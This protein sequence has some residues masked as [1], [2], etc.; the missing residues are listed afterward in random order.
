MNARRIMQIVEESHSITDDKWGF[1]G[2][3]Y[4]YRKTDDKE[5]ISP[6]W[7]HILNHPELVKQLKVTSEATKSHQYKKYIIGSIDEPCV[8]K[9]LDLTLVELQYL[10]SHYEYSKCRQHFIN[11]VTAFVDGKIAIRLC[12]MSE[13]NMSYSISPDDK[14]CVCPECKEYMMAMC[15]L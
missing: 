11:T 4:Q 10:F 8:M 6:I 7:Q 12:S 15:G 3:T 1:P 13:C 5:E 9:Y 2:Y 14:A